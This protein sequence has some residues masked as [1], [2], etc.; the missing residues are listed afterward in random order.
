MTAVI[1]E[2]TG[3]ERIKGRKFFYKVGKLPNRGRDCLTKTNRMIKNLMQTMLFPYYL[4]RGRS[5]K[6][7]EF[8]KILGDEFRREL[9][10]EVEISEEDILLDFYKD[11]EGR[12]F[13]ALSYNYDSSLW[14]VGFDRKVQRKSYRWVD[15]HRQRVFVQSRLNE[16]QIIPFGGSGKVLLKGKRGGKAFVSLF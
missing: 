6:L 7:E 1:S 11:D 2:L 10:K 5:L 13:P 9:G 14:L 4:R 16:K 3:S 15:E 12:I 8:K